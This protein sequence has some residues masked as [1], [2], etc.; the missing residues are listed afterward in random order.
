M[1]VIRHENLFSS[2]RVR[3]IETWRSLNGG[4]EK[5]RITRLGGS[6]DVL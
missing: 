5:G 4:R 6:T 3:I 2:P 1:K